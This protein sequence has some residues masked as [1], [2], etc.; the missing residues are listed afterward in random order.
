MRA[1]GLGAN[2]I[3]T[4]VEPLAGLEATMD[5]FRVMTMEKAAPL[6]D[7][8]CTVTGNIHVIRKKHFE[9]MRDGAIVANSGHFNVEL[10]LDAL[11]EITTSKRVI[12][13]YV[14][15]HTLDKR[16]E[17]QRPRRRKTYKSHR[18]RGASFKRNGHEF[19]QPG[20]LL[21]AHSEKRAGS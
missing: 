11:S 13:E 15:E 12:R 14:E 16:K 17:N 2:V 6:G 18:G 8:F 9:K 4:E 21:R 19:R 1:R 10:D 5:G 3:V 20:A 7:F